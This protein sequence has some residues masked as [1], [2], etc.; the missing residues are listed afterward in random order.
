[1]PENCLPRLLLFFSAILFFASCKKETDDGSD[2]SGQL[3]PLANGNKWIYVDSFFTTTGIYKGKDTF[4]LKTAETINFSNQVFTPITDQFDDSIFIVRSDDTTVFILEPPGESLMFRWPVN[5][6]QPVI[7]N[8]YQGDIM[9]SMIFTELNATT[10]Y[11]AYKIVIT[12]NDGQW[13]NYRQQELFFSIGLGIIKGRNIRKTGT[14]D[15]YT[16]DTYHLLS[17]TVK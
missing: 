7:T 8:S 9:N 16:T 4:Y 10:N 1:M 3:F 12:Q 13:A 2:Q 11:P 14:G 5:T 15:F 6:G 17:Y